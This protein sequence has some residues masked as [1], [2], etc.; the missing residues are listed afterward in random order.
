M[1][2]G[3]RDRRPE[4]LATSSAAERRQWLEGVVSPGVAVRILLVVHHR[5][6]ENLSQCHEFRAHRRSS[7]A[8]GT[9]HLWRGHG[10]LVL[11]PPHRAALTIGSVLIYEHVL[12]ATSWVWV[13]EAAA[14]LQTADYRLIRY[15]DRY[16][17]LTFPPAQVAWSKG[18]RPACE[19]IDEVAAHVRAWGLSEVSW[20]VSELTAPSD[21][22]PVLIARG[23]TLRES[24]QV[25]AYDFSAGLPQLETRD[26]VVAELVSD[27]PR[28]RSAMLVNA[29]G[30]GSSV[31]P[32]SHKSSSG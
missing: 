15:P 19:L 28:L 7:W 13:P 11:G 10:H 30:W 6:T 32:S 17:D 3:T 24:Y 2:W 1:V 20:A 12:E 8:S 27:E 25:L 5:A 31:M 21:I 9:S 23:A 16:C 18:D 22:E 29:A 14:E 4:I 26:D